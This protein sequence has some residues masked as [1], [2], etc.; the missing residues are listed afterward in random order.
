MRVFINEKPQETSAQVLQA[1]MEELGLAQ[2]WGVA[3]AVEG[4]VV[5]RSRWATQGLPEGCQILVI[6]AAQG[7]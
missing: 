1:L 4:Q 7:G 3:V 6:R 5:P 2:E